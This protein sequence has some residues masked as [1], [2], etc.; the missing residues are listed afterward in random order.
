MSKNS[1]LFPDCDFPELSESNCKK[2]VGSPTAGA[3]PDSKS[4][5]TSPVVPQPSPPPISPSA[6][7]RNSI[8]KLQDFEFNQSNWVSFLGLLSTTLSSAVLIIERQESEISALKENLSNQST[9]LDFNKKATLEIK[10]NITSCKD[11]I[12]SLKA[13]H[14]RKE[15]SEKFEQCHNSVKISNFPSKNLKNVENPKSIIRDFL[16]NQ[17]ADIEN[18]LHDVKITPLVKLDNFSKEELPVLLSCK[19][20]SAKTELESAIRNNIPHLKMTYHFPS[21]LYKQ[22][23]QIRERF[24]S[25]CFSID[26]TEYDLTEQWIMIRPN[27]NF[28]KL[29]LLS[30]DPKAESW[31]FITLL[32]IPSENLAN[33]KNYSWGTVKWLPKKRV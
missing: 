12:S 24:A 14:K 2:R 17:G 30:K 25:N 5:K 1:E 11:S 13:Q 32:D 7:I 3:S 33:L 15:V 31:K 16:G 19:N 20:N 18:A 23:K 22:V 27:A 10:S 8:N 9:S 4:A 21:T 29:K 26:S 28:T 6:E